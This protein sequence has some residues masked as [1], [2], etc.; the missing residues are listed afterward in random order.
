MGQG[1]Q[2]WDLVSWAG[3]L[4]C[5]SEKD[6]A[7]KAINGGHCQDCIPRAL[8]GLQYHTTKSR[9]PS[10]GHILDS[11][12]TLSGALPKG[13]RKEGQKNVS[14]GLWPGEAAATLTKE[15]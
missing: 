14:G 2:L 9:V 3:V 10:S 6:L 8:K 1:Q 15:K 13:E 7:S 12:R 4:L 11:Q 5:M